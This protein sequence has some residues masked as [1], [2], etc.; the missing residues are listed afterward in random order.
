MQT[1]F[2]AYS[3]SKMIGLRTAKQTLHPT[4]QRIMQGNN[5]SQ[6]VD[7][8]RITTLTLGQSLEGGFLCPKTSVTN[9][10]NFFIHIP[11]NLIFQGFPLVIHIIHRNV[12]CLFITFR[13]VS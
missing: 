10:V 4:S 1:G 7:L 3:M 13:H 5:R 11:Q 9:Q 8:D 6:E 12:F 2:A